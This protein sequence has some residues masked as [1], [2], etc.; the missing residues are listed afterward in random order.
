MDVFNCQ[1]QIRPNMSTLLM[2]KN[3]FFQILNQ[4]LNKIRKQNKAKE[5]FKT[6]EQNYL[7]ASSAQHRPK[8]FLLKSQIVARMHVFQ[9]EVAAVLQ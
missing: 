7:R 2:A 4:D 1:I 5:V 6:W 9:L 3:H 8:K